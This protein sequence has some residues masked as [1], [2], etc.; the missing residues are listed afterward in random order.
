M[1]P[2]VVPR[3][4]GARSLAPLY[5]EKSNLPEPIGEAWLTGIDCRI[6][7]GPFAG[8]TLG[9]AWRQMPQ[10][11]RGT[12]VNAASALPILLKFIFPA[13][14]LSLPVNPHSCHTT[15]TKESTG[16]PGDTGVR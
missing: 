9:K 2:P 12:N 13:E 14:Q 5:P 3:L 10:E 7:T 1:E 11:W 8:K 16:T 4:W 6:A 15:S